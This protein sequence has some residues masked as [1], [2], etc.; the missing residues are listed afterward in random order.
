MTDVAAPEAVTLRIPEKDAV[1]LARLLDA[2]AQLRNELRHA[3]ETH[4][5]RGDEQSQDRV[6]DVESETMCQAQIVVRAVERILD[7]QLPR[8]ARG[9]S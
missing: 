1:E 7:A 9:T 2:Q 6:L 5:R 4:Q 8:P 3:R